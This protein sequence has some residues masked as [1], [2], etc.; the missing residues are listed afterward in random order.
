MK[1]GKAIYN[2]LSADANV[3][4]MVSNRIFPSIANIGTAFPFIIYSI[5]GD[6][7]QKDKDGKSTL[8]IMSVTISAYSDQYE[9]ATNLGSHIRAALDRVPTYPSTTYNGIVLQSIEFTGYNDIFDDDSGARGIYRKAL[10]FRIRQII[11]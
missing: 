6:D 5:T 10:D 11:S 7:P 8:D 2:I 3:S 1:L 4:D 9:K